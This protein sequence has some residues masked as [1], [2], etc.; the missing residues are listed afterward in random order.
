MKY[1]KL[2]RL[3][4]SR[5]FAA[6]NHIQKLLLV[7]ALFLIAVSSVLRENHACHAD[8]LV[9][10]Y[11]GLYPPCCES[12]SQVCRG[13]PADCTSIFCISGSMAFKGEFDIGVSV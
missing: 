7:Q 8:G 3:T 9:D 1:D 6:R 11:S 13:A 5:M 12:H 4:L 10:T 2:S